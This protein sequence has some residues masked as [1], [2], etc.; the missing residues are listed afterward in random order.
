MK[1]PRRVFCA[2]NFKTAVFFLL[3]AKW[4][5]SRFSPQNILI[6]LSTDHCLKVHSRWGQASNKRNN[7]IF[8]SQW[9]SN[10]LLISSLWK[11]NDSNLQNYVFDKNYR[12]SSFPAFVLNYEL[13]FQNREK[14]EIGFFFSGESKKF[15]FRSKDFF[16]YEH[17]LLRKLTVKRGGEGVTEARRRGGVLADCF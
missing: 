13:N 17:Q 15:R 5:T 11:C 2:K 1:N 8:F 12:L 7:W 6:T 14:I 16:P 10:H 3:A 9:F 4:P